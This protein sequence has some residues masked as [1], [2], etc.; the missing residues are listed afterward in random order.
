M[1]ITRLA[2][3]CLATLTIDVGSKW[4]VLA[5]RAPPLRLGRHVRLG[6]ARLAPAD[7]LLRLRQLLKNQRR[8]RFQPLNAPLP[9][10]VQLARFKTLPSV[11]AL[12][13]DVRA[14]APPS[15]DASV[16]SDVF[17][18]PGDDFALALGRD[19]VA[20]TCAAL[21][22]A[23]PIGPLDFSF[24]AGLFQFHV[25]L[26]AFNVD[27]QSGQLVLSIDGHAAGRTFL[28]PDFDFTLTQAAT[29]FVSGGVVGVQPLGGL[30]LAI[31]D[32]I[33]GF[34]I[35]LFEGPIVSLPLRRLVGREVALSFWTSWATASLLELRRLARLRAGG[36]PFVIA[37]NDGEDPELARRV[38]A[39]LDGDVQL[40]CD[41][42]RTIARAY[43][44]CCW[45]TTVWLDA[46]GRT[47]RVQLGRTAATMARL[48]AEETRPDATEAEKSSS[49]RQ[50]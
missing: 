8:S 32:G 28:S 40:V 25:T 9:A 45:P 16:V 39:E 24:A 41:V 10:A 12:L 23:N 15:P 35:G 4:A 11:A 42:H 13:V 26:T 3:A 43:G 47:A 46:H 6:P 14:D 17:L 30:G 18:A 7:D 33:T 34:I 44:G 2:V 1:S 20:A 21:F 36:G 48:A 27:L 29:L 31:H 38:L 5:R 19:F 50:A 37:I 22:E 49:V